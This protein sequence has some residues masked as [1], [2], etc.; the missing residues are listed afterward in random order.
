VGF[1]RICSTS[2]QTSL[3][4]TSAPLVLAA[5]STSAPLV[6][7]ASSTSASLA[8]GDPPTGSTKSRDSQLGMTAAA[9]TRPTSAGF[10]LVQ[11]RSIGPLIHFR[12]IGPLA[13]FRTTG[14]VRRLQ[15]DNNS[16]QTGLQIVLSNTP[17]S[18]L[19]VDKLSKSTAAG[20]NK[21]R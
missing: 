20:V 11:F 19:F 2:L 18:D 15:H 17:Q 16:S 5:S 1:V 12:A 8:V 13:H 6:L 14:A 9:A 4:G 10:P 21:A 3:F 7:A